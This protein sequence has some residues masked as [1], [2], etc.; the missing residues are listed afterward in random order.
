MLDLSTLLRAWEGDHGNFRVVV[1]ILSI[2]W[3]NLFEPL[4]KLRVLILLLS[5]GEGSLRAIQTT[6]LAGGAVRAGTTA[7]R[8]ERALPPRWFCI[9]IVSS[10]FRVVGITFSPAAAPTAT[11]ATAPATGWSWPCPDRLVRLH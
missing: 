9:S 5:L 7:D 4:D 6:L 8:A 11:A 2:R 10:S 1:L 3:P